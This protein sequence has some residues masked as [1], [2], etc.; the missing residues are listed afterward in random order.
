MNGKLLMIGWR[1]LALLAVIVF[2]CCGCERNTVETGN[3]QDAGVIDE[4]KMTEKIS[5]QKDEDGEQLEWNDADSIIHILVVVDTSGSMSKTHFII[6]EVLQLVE[7]LSHINPALQVEYISFDADGAESVLR[8]EMEQRFASKG[9]T[10]VYKGMEKTKEWI[11]EH[12]SDA[13]SDSNR[14]GIII[15]SD[16]FSSRT[17]NNDLYNKKSAEEEQEELK[18]WMEDWKQKEAEGKLSMCFITWESL[19]PGEE[20]EKTYEFLE[21]EDGKTDEA[22]FQRGF[23]VVMDADGDNT[24]FLNSE[25]MTEKDGLDTLE[26]NAINHCLRYLAEIAFGEGNVSQWEEKKNEKWKSKITY[27]KNDYCYM[28][29]QISYPESVQKD[30]VKITGIKDKDERNAIP[31]TI[32]AERILEGQ[33]M[34]LYY[35]SNAKQYEEI[36][37]EPVECMVSRFGVKDFDVDISV[38][39]KKDKSVEVTITVEQGGDYCLPKEFKVE[40]LNKK[41]DV[42]SVSECIKIKKIKEECKVTLNTNKESHKVKIY[43]LDDDGKWQLEA[44]RDV[45]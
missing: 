26:R 33:Y 45:I 18:Q 35:V 39:E 2:V 25:D 32:S 6:C 19:T 7:V 15:L 36:Y 1:Y 43:Y 38:T 41:G 4:E 42:I 30:M 11:D 34:D 24:F 28:F 21:K 23:Q 16:L 31:E 17:K 13:D 37:I 27:K 12:C 44:E 20:R 10:S 22:V 5:E 3:I 9:E 14:V 40:C 29:L 8:E